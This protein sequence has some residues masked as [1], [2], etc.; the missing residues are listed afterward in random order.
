MI[1]VRTLGILPLIYTTIHTHSVRPGTIAHYLVN[2]A[3]FSDSI[4]KRIGSP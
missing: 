4:S 3:N 1:P 2:L